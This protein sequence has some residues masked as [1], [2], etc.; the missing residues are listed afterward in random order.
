V[1]S[2]IPV[3]SVVINFVNLKIKSVQLFGYAHRGRV[4]MR[5]FI[6]LSARIC[7]SIYVLFCVSKKK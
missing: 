4:C 1:G 7:M 2:D 6:G 3:D 5:V